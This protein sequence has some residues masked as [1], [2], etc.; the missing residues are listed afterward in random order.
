LKT[1][2]SMYDYLNCGYVSVKI[3]HI[4][5]SQI[6]EAIQKQLEEL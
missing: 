1:K 3:T 2:R 6:Y 5:L 4:F